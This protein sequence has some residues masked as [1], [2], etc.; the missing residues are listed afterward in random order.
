MN[1]H[2]ARLMQFIK[3]SELKD[4]QIDEISEL[5]GKIEK[6][7]SPIKYREYGFFHFDDSTKK[8]GRYKLDS[9]EFDNLEDLILWSRAEREAQTTLRGKGN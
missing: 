3:Y 1:Q 5:M 4:K 8:W 7:L 9:P 6:L 2:L